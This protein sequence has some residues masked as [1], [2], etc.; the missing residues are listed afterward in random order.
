MAASELS[1][2]SALG[3]SP[4]FNMNPGGM[5]RGGLVFGQGGSTDDILPRMLSNGEY[6]MQAGA[7]STY[8]K[9]F[10]DLVNQGGLDPKFTRP[11]SRSG[12]AKALAAGGHSSNAEYNISVS[13]AGT[14]ASPEDIARAVERAM[15][16]KEQARG[17]SRRI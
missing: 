14:D 5:R 8:G 6:V 3:L 16:R 15:R 4:I 2:L 9:G 17:T 13:V 10:M 11:S 7:V 12:L 1:N